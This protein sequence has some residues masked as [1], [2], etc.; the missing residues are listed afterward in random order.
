MKLLKRT[1]WF[2]ATLLPNLVFLVCVAVLKGLPSNSQLLSALG[3]QSVF[4]AV[5]VN[6]MFLLAA[7][8]FLYL[9]GNS[10]R[11]LVLLQVPALRFLAGVVVIAPTLT[12]LPLLFSLFG[13]RGTW[14]YALVGFLFL[15]SFGFLILFL[16]SLWKAMP[17]SQLLRFRIGQTGAALIFCFSGWLIAF[18]LTSID[19]I[20]IG[21]SLGVVLITGIFLTLLLSIVA[22]LLRLGRTGGLLLALAALPLLFWNDGH[23]ISEARS[24]AEVSMERAISRERQGDVHNSLHKWLLTRNDLFRY[25]DSDRPYPVLILMSS[26][27]GGYAA[28]HAYSFQVKAQQICPMFTQHLFAAIG[29][30]GGA[31]GNFLASYANRKHVNPANIVD[32]CNGTSQSED[33]VDEV[34]HRDMLSPLVMKLLFSDFPNRLFFGMLSSSSRVDTFRELLV[35][36]SGDPDASSVGIF[37]HFWNF[38]DDGG[39]DVSGRPAQVPIATDVRTGYDFA[40]APFPLW[41]GR[42]RPTVAALPPSLSLLRELNNDPG[43]FDISVIDAV[44]ASAAFPYVT[45]ALQLNLPDTSGNEAKAF[46]LVD[47]GYF[48]GSGLTTALKIYSDYAPFF[49]SIRK[50]DVERLFASRLTHQ[51]TMPDSYQ[52]GMAR[53]MECDEVTFLFVN[54]SG[55]TTEIGTSINDI[56]RREFIDEVF[57][58]DPCTIRFTLHFISLSTAN[59]SKPLDDSSLTGG[60]LAQGEEPLTLQRYFLDPLI[61]MMNARLARV[62]NGKERFLQ[63]FCPAC[64]SDQVDAFL[65]EGYLLQHFYDVQGL[66]IPL[67]WDMPE[68]RLRQA[69]A[70]VLPDNGER[71]REEL[72]AGCELWRFA[73]DEQRALRNAHE[74]GERICR[75]YSALVDEVGSLNSFVRSMLVVTLEQGD[76]GLPVWIEPTRNSDE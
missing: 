20:G 18:I 50:E 60:Q 72:T 7:G 5:I 44:L 38:N 53:L 34:L 59:S 76:L 64:R 54:S 31:V 41:H 30:S 36:A 16:Q 68:A 65:R 6:S 63:I 14:V 21:R 26:G 70:T 74:Q 3:E 10:T 25:I 67:G 51:E 73:E 9:I 42:S 15:A 56:A 62:G 23:H 19:P 66:Q 43:A 12:Y 28:A 32:K 69:N 2:I 61:T 52:V 35:E 57:P 17:P 47:G 49:N 1:A 75:N 22:A 8:C 39:I 33:I 37:S 71:E 11:R 27:G 13:A 58:R 55:G 45:P 4:M 29:I 48:D 40:M 24:G 46:K